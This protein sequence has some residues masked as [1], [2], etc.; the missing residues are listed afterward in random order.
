MFGYGFSHFPFAFFFY[1]IVFFLCC[2]FSA[3][4]QSVFIWLKFKTPIVGIVIQDLDIGLNCFIVLSRFMR[5]DSFGL[6]QNKKL[7]TVNC[8]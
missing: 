7:A 2:V 1:F 8:N 6:I 5:F 4:T 3:L